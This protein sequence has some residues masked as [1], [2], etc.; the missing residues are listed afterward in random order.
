VVFRRVETTGTAR[1]ERVE[2]EHRE[3]GY[4]DETNTKIY[5]AGCVRDSKKVLENEL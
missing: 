3:D 5:R 2:I 1:V 4:E